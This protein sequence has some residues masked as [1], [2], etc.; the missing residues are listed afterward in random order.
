MKYLGNVGAVCRFEWRRSKTWAR[1]FL[2]L[3]LT[4]FPVGIML[5]MR[6]NGAEPPRHFVAGMLLVLV[7]MVMCMLGVFLW[8]TP[9]I[10]AEVERGSWVYLTVRPR[11]GIAVLLGKY[12]V[13]LGWTIPAAILGATLALIAAPAGV[14][15]QDHLSELQVDGQALTATD[16]IPELSYVRVWPVL[17]VL[18]V[19]S[20]MTYGAAY[21]LIGVLFQRRSMVVAVAYTLVFEVL[22]GFVPAMVNKLTIQ[23]RLRS[24]Y[25][26]W[27]DVPLPQNRGRGIDLSEFLSDA[28]A[29]HNAS[30]LG[31]MTIG[32]LAAAALA[33]RSRELAGTAVAQS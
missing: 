23:F 17:V 18:S 20:S 32:F 21:T 6:F 8:A 25:V 30:V 33:L 2:W 10:S 12:L 27:L 28:P 24:M 7:P 26:T 5:L 22:V 31:L 13:A 14:S 19:L 11:G 3:L 29:W 4:L 9:A 16:P 15:L 1:T